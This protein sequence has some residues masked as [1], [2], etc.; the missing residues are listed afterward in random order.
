MERLLAKINLSNF[1]QSRE[2]KFL[3]KS[4]RSLVILQPMKGKG[5]KKKPSRK[6]KRGGFIS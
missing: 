6:A 1:A 4:S 3:A 5:G 2:E